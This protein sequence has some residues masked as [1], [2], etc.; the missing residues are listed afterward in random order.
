M[1]KRSSEREVVRHSLLP[2]GEELHCLAGPFH[3]QL[4]AVV[5]LG[6]DPFVLEHIRTSVSLP[7]CGSSVLESQLL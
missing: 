6:V 2:V 5:P 3:C 1:N 7:A 4:R